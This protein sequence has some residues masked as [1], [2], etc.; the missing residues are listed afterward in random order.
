[1]SIYQIIALEEI[2]DTH[3]YDIHPFL[4]GEPVTRELV[5]SIN[6]SGILHPPVVLESPNGSYDVICG[7][8]RLKCVDTVLHNSECL[9]CL[10]PLGNKPEDLL[11]ILLEDQFCHSA[12]SIIEQS[13]FID[14]CKKLIPEKKALRSFLNSIPQGRI[15]GGINFLAPLIELDQILQKKIHFSVISEK[16]VSELQKYNRQDQIRVANLIENLQLG[17][18]NQKKLLQFLTEILI[19]NEVSLVSLL[20]ENNIEE[21]LNHQKMNSPQKTTQLFTVFH[22][23]CYPL[24]SSAEEIFHQDVRELK[25][26]EHC[27]VNATQAFEK[28]DITLSIQFKDFKTLEDVWPD[29]A[30]ILI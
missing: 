3:L 17:I 21:I 28:D 26:P 4:K 13:W 12:L 25:L 29:I 9:C 16:I 23:M 7:R 19:R 6:V 30:K 24:L 5:D 14:V 20:A 10:L 27:R 22:E 2:C 8:Q 15:V 1:M 18:N 11:N